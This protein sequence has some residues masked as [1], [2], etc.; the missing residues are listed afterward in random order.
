M[1]ELEARMQ[2]I[3]LI[4]NCID[5][6]SIDDP[7]FVEMSEGVIHCACDAGDL[8]YKVVLVPV[9]EEAY[10]VPNDGGQPIKVSE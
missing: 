5:E 4:G 8:Y 10:F 7:S 1:T 9:P 6:E 3:R 2:L